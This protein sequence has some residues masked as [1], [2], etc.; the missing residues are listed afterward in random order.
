MHHSIE[1]IDVDVSVGDIPLLQGVNIEAMPCEL[2]AIV[3]DNG[4]GKTTL[5]KVTNGTF[6]PDRG[7]VHVMHQDFLTHKDPDV[8]RREIAMVPQKSNYH[9]FPIRVE[10]AV[11]MGRYGKI[12]LMRRP[13]DEDLAIAREAM[14]MTGILSFAK[15]LVHELS[16]GQ[17]QKVSLARALAQE[18]EIL[19]LD[20]PTTHLDASSRTEIMETIRMMHRER[21]LTTLMVSHEAEWV[22]QYADKVYFLKDGTSHL[23]T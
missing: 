21:H 2:A 1:L 16:G 14:R 11:L 4:T 13:K 18:P 7:K 12:G 19:L 10:E 23:M 5:L 15:K 9:R 3:G 22:R 20:E 6:R 17:Q 8:L